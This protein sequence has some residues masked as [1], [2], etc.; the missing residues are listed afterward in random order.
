MNNKFWRNK[1]V[2]ITG[3]EGFLGS[4][5]TLK[6]LNL[7]ADVFGIDILTRRKK[8]LFTAADYK[9]LTVFKGDVANYPFVKKI[10]T[11]NRISVVFHLAAEALVGRCLKNPLRTFSSNIRGTWNVA[12]ASRNSSYVQAII[13]A[14]SDKAYGCHKKLPYT[15]DAPLSGSF[16]YDVSKSCTDLIAKTYANTY[17]VPVAITRCG[18]IFG[19]GDFNTSRIVVDAILSMIGKRKLIIRSDGKFTR[20]YVYV[21]DIVSA[22]IL[23]AEKLKKCRLEGEAFN[24]SYERPLSVLQLVKKI[25]SCTGEK[26]SYKV[27]GEAKYEIKNQYLSSKKARKLLGWK[28]KYGREDGLGKTINWYKSCFR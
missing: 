12:E 8:T 26:P 17:A 9:N 1:R 24:F 7:G 10:L 23:L 25:Y 14:S 3:F 4:N 18:N 28:P 6:L 16:P 21:D 5:L 15:E 27:L 2:L 19:P 13:I 22:Y 20:D 11:K